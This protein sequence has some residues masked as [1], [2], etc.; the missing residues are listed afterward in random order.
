MF[1]SDFCGVPSYCVSLAK[2]FDPTHWHGQISSLA[3]ACHPHKV[4][5]SMS[6]VMSVADWWDLVRLHI[7][8]YERV[9]ERDGLTD[10][11]EVSVSGFCPGSLAGVLHH[12]SLPSSSSARERKGRKLSGSEFSQWDGRSDSCCAVTEVARLL[13]SSQVELQDQ[14]IAAWTTCWN[15]KYLA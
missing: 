14:P 13:E 1:L 8:R 2:I 4:S 7:C 11:L 12:G 5:S 10:R 9:S 15:E 6:V 3:E